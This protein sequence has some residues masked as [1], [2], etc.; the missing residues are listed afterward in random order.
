M[1]YVAVRA[2]YLTPPFAGLRSAL[3]DRRFPPV[4]AKELPSLRCTVSLLCA[5]EKAADWA[6]WT[7]GVHGLIVEFTGAEPRL[8]PLC[9]AA[10]CDEPF[11][12]VARCEAPSA[13]VGICSMRRL[14]GLMHVRR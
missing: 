8:P 6:D 4:A 3:R 5:F 9:R 7:V 10:C 12:N 11:R 13:C 2:C 14:L 1:C